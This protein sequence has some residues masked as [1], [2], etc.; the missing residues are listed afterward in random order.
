MLF[1]CSRH[2]CRD[3]QNNN[4]S[5]T[6]AD[7]QAREGLYYVRRNSGDDNVQFKATTLDGQN[8]MVFVMDDNTGLRVNTWKSGGWGTQKALATKDDIPTRYG[9]AGIEIPAGKSC[10][11]SV[12]KNGLFAALLFVQGSNGNGFGT[13][14]IQGYGLD[15]GPTR[16]RVNS[17]NT[18]GTQSGIT[19]TVGDGAYFMVKNGAYNNAYMVIEE[20]FNGSAFMHSII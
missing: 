13:F 18:S 19:C 5:N 16:Y 20:F 11:I 1:Q 4:L 14:M 17:L 10:K 2:R 9:G 8:G 12:I 7:V 15:G 3:P 6:N